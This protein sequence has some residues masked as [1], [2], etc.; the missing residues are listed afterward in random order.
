M[1]GRLT[2]A[3]IEGD[4]AAENDADRTRAAGAQAVAI[5]AGSA[6][7]LNADVVHAASH[8]ID[9]RP[10]D[11]L[12]SQNVD[13][14]AYPACFVLGRP[15]NVDLLSVTEGDDKPEKY[16]ACFAPLTCPC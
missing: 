5:T 12:S 11:L 8:H 10:I 2:V 1:R 13:N 3:A 7:H 9:L 15:C 14:R 16:P 6:S 4:A